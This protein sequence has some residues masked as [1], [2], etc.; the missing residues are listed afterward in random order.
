LAGVDKDD[1]LEVKQQGKGIINW[2]TRGQLGVESK[3]KATTGFKA[4]DYDHS[5][6]VTYFKNVLKSSEKYFEFSLKR[7][8]SAKD[9]FKRG[10]HVVPILKNQKQKGILNNYLKGSKI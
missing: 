10:G 1:A 2:T 6:L 8:R 4:Y 5:E 3:I 7:L 9:I